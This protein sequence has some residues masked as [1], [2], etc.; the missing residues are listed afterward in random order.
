[1]VSSTAVPPV[2]ASE[3]A[4]FGGKP[5]VPQEGF[6]IGVDI[7]GTFTD[8]VVLDERAGEVRT[9]KVPSTPH[10]PSQAVL[11]AVRR[12]HG[13][14]GI[15]L[16][17]VTQF[18]HATTVA[19]NTI[20][21]GSGARTG[22]LVTDG[23]RDV[24]QIQRHKRFRLFDL[25][26]KKIP[27]LVPRHLIYGI[28]ER[29]DAAG[30][31]VRAL[32]EE[33]V[34][35]AVDAL[36]REGIEALAICFLFSFRNATHEQR[37]AEIAREILPDAFVTISS[38]VLPQYR[39]YERTST[40]SVNG[41]LGPRMSRYLGNMNGS[42][43]ENGIRAPLHLMQSNGGVLHWQE[44]SRMPCR[45][46]ESGPAA[47][48]I[49][50]AHFGAVAGR[51]HLIAFDMGGTTAK[52]GLVEDGKVRQSDGQEVGAGINISRVLQGGGYYIGAPTVDLAEVGAGGGSI[53]W[54]DAAGMLK[55][56]PRSAG[57]DPGPIAYGLGGERVT[58]T[59][60]NLLLG[61]IPADHFL[62]GEMQLDVERARR[63]LEN[64]IAKPLGVSVDDACA[65]IIEVANASM[66]KMLRIVTVEKGL[67]PADFTLVA[68]GGNGPVFGIELA[69]DLGMREVI[70]PPAPGLLSAQG[71]L[72]AD[73]RYDFRQTFV[74]AVASADL[75]EIEARFAALEAQGRNALQSH[76]IGEAAIVATRTADMR[77][78]RQAYELNVPLPQGALAAATL[79][80]LVESFH[81]AHERLYGRR[82]AAGAVEIVNL[83]VA[84]TGNVT[85]PE[86]REIAA[87][88]GSARP[89]GKGTRK[90]F[91]ANR[92]SFD[93]VRYE[94]PQL[95]AGDSLQGPAIVEAADSTTLLPPDWSLRCDRIGNLFATRGG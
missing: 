55:V 22:L 7:G 52:A 85:R 41:L 26:Y 36:R 56:G 25:A 39:E 14:F 93:C 9:L 5:P 82:D 43:E 51:K 4:P 60:A 83:C 77:Y 2:L 34:A 38:D 45:I 30:A 15:D 89:A 94:R 86:Y 32:N 78:R 20:L 12:L 69:D 74:G 80:A 66:L 91:F 46:V 54:L 92:G 47:G 33:A 62:G 58:V 61:R 53:A 76:G 18:T 67:D 65:A 90:V 75:A 95:R 29:I 27:P 21:E 3:R 35:A 70:I 64:T 73:L 1:M 8:L 63:V 87:G 42:L 68:F 16:A 31:V 13:E 71:L 11:N 81:Q 57:A 72:A 50:A 23:F 44:A 19:C 40:T 24:L 84:L 49:A 37:A 10:D 48:V 59:D 6:R 17:Q 79:P 28:P 88:D